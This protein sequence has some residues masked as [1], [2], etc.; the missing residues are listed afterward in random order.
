M[1]NGT[2]GILTYSDGTT[3][4]AVLIEIETIPG[5][6]HYWFRYPEDEP[7]KKIKHET[8]ADKFPIPEKIA[9]RV[10]TPDLFDTVITEEPQDTQE[11]VSGPLDGLDDILGTPAVKTVEMPAGYENCEQ[12]YR[13]SMGQEDMPM[14]IGVEAGS[15]NLSVGFNGAAPVS[16][17]KKHLFYMVNAFS[18][19]SSK[20]L[21]EHYGEGNTEFMEGCK[22]AAQDMVLA[23]VKSG[24][25]AE[26]PMIKGHNAE[27]LKKALAE[28]A[29]DFDNSEVI[30]GL[31]AQIKET[32]A[33]AAQAEEFTKNMSEE[34]RIAYNK[35]LQKKQ[36]DLLEKKSLEFERTLMGTLEQ[37]EAVNY[38]F[39]HYLDIHKA[40]GSAALKEELSKLPEDEREE[41]IA[42]I[43]E[44]YKLKRQNQSN[45]EA[46]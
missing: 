1:Q 32:E 29:P 8:Y 15:K 22:D 44:E 30:E 23:T 17:S 31:T 19:M 46:N 20:L 3:S 39:E 37:E 18:A 4:R 10:F 5:G 43:K 34:E 42:K 27:E 6:N 7:N 41:V 21:K 12:V 2:T 40:H 9:L 33:L 36:N 14:Y 26:E 25:S 13:A 35:E 24:D 16:I 38:S 11:E 28:E 45:E